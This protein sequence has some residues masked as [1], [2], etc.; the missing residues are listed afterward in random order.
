MEHPMEVYG[1]N[2]FERFLTDVLTV[3][4]WLLVLFVIATG[5]FFGAFFAGDLAAG[6]L[7]TGTAL[8]GVLLLLGSSGI[9]QNR[10][11]VDAAHF[12][13]AVAGLGWL[14]NGL[15][16]SK[17]GALLTGVTLLLLFALIL[18]LRQLAVQARF[19]PRFFSLRQFETMVQIAD[20]MID[21]DGREA[22]HPIQVAI[23]IDHLLD[24]VDTPL[25]Q[26]IKRVMLLVEWLLPL[27]I[28]RPI[29]FS[30]LGSNE[31]RRV[32]GKVIGAKGIFRDV[33]RTLKMLAC[34]GYYGNPE[35]MAQVGYV[36]F[37]ERQRS[38]GVEQTPLEFVDPFSYG[39]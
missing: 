23:E 38:Q 39:D 24:D 4:G 7:I 21:G 36:P 30:D 12:M 2:L 35:G 11:S 29:P 22:L 32:V 17:L 10:A 34:I 37:E 13:L 9:R 14:V 19:K 6:A 20:T 1:L 16:A 25:R 33:A 3:L 31:R 5:L 28:G 15:L 8:T 26:D 18:Y 27:L